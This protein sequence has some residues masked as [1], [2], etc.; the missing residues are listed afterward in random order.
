MGIEDNVVI[1]LDNSQYIADYA[2]TTPFK[3]KV[4]HKYNN[5]IE[6]VSLLTDKLYELYYYQIL[7]SL[8]TDEIIKL[9]N[10]DEYG[11]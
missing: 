3:A 8:E 10:L 1:V 5:T 6:V 2:E 9:I 4:F 11:T 7:E